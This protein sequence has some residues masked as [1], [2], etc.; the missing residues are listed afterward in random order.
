MELGSQLHVLTALSPGKL[1]QPG[2]CVDP[3]EVW[4]LWRTENPI[5]ARN[6]TLA[7]L[8]VAS[9]YMNWA[10]LPFNLYSFVMNL[11]AGRATNYC[12]PMQGQWPH[13]RIAPQEVE[14]TGK[15]RK[16]AC[17]PRH[18]KKYRKTCSGSSRECDWKH[19]SAAHRI[20]TGL[21]R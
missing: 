9:H 13:Q 18:E 21:L 15:E 19:N 14:G 3:R 20:P 7:I 17:S 11:I 10:V 8:T 2:S 16:Q 1:L 12:S 5:P 6:E 4:C